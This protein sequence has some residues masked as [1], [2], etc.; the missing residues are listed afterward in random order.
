M[1]PAWL[2]GP[3]REVLEVDGF[4]I[5]SY[6]PDDANEMVDAVT[7]SIDHLRPWMPWIAYEPQTVEQRRTLIA[8]WRR[9]WDALESFGYGMFANDRLVGGCGLHVRSGPG[10]LEIG[11]WVHVDHVNK[12]IATL[13]ASTML[14]A[15][16]ERAEVESVEIV[17]DSENVA[18]RRVPEK[19]G[20]AFVGEFLRA[21]DPR[22]AT[23]ALA[24]GES[25]RGCRWRMVRDDWSGNRGQNN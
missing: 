8:E 7:R 9:E 25:G 5:R 20:F 10:I 21:D 13:A 16:F 3:P 17:H 1:S 12:G 4:V 24:P 11:Y 14:D 22:L 6:T 18:S 2:V 19:L 23:E 15:A